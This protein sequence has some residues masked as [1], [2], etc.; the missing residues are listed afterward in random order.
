MQGPRDPDPRKADILSGWGETEGPQPGLRWGKGQPDRVSVEGSQALEAQFFLDASDPKM[1]LTSLVFSNA[2]DSW[3][4]QSWR[5][6]EMG[7][8]AGFAGSF[9]PNSSR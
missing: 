3:R 1:D 2:L 4:P 8:E 9:E 7:G 5:T 6:S